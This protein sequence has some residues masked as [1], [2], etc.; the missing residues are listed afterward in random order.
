MKTDNKPNDTNSHNKRISFTDNFN[1]LSYLS[2]VV[3]TEGILT[4][5]KG[6]TG[7]LVGWVISFG[8]YFFWYKVFKILF[9]MNKESLNSV[10]IIFVS[11]FA[12]AISSILTTPIWI[13]QARMWVWKEKKSVVTH[14]EEIYKEG[15]IKAFWK[16]IIPGLILVINPVINFV[17]YENLRSIVTE[18]DSKI[19]SVISIFVISIIGKIWATIFTYP[20]LKSFLANWKFLIKFINSIK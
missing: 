1:S 17:I 14:W 19:P 3:K 15:G 13:L 11:S 8:L 12:G 9:Q 18:S 4:F 10:D 5:Y 16:G 7:S 6:L 20:I 2:R